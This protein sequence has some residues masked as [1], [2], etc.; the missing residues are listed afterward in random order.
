MNNQPVTRD[1]RS[2]AVENASY[3]VAY[4]VM[5]YG[6]LAIVAYRGFVLQ[7]SS[8]DLLALVVLGGATATVYQGSN[9]V[10]SRYWVMATIAALILA[11]L[12]GIIFVLILR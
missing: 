9:K 3:R 5:S 8:W 6:A 11:V 1:E 4:L 12:L 2:T 10:L 7:Q